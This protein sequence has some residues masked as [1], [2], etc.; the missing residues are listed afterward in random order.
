MAMYIMMGKYSLD[1]IGKISAERTTKGK[2]IVADCE[3][4]LKGGYAM[5]GE[6]DLILIAEFP[7]TEKAI[8]ASTKLS[9]EL[10]IGF[11][12]AP[13]ITMEDFDK[14]IAGK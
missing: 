8:K 14:V 3:G 2:K 1:A 7:N 12:T 11:S 4:S 6:R 13:A 5:L 9:K 10:G